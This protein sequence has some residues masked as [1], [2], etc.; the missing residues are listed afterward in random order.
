M[1][2]PEILILGACIY[3]LA[4]HQDS[5]AWCKA[6]LSGGGPAGSRIALLLFRGETL[7]ERLFTDFGG[8]AKGLRRG[9]EAT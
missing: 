4:P 7:M 3:P 8:R 6:G 1:A 2:L 5:H 9:A